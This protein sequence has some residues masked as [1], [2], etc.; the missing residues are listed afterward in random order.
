MK[1][2]L[3]WFLVGM[4]MAVALAWA[5]PEPGSSGGW[6]H[7]H[8][9]TKLGV[10]LIFFLHG[11]LLSFADLREGTMRW[12]V[13]LLVQSSTFLIFPLLGLGLLA[14]PGLLPSAG[15]R[16]GVFLLCALPSTVSSSVALTAAARGNVP[17]AVFNATLS[18][19]LGFVLTPLWIGLLITASGQ[20]LPLGQVILDLFYWLVL[21]L[22]IGQLIRPWLGGWAQHHK[23]SINRVDRGVILFLVYTS[24]CDSM[25]R[26]IWTENGWKLIMLL[27]VI[28]I[29]L[30]FVI[31]QIVR[32]LIRLLRFSKEDEIATIFCGSQKTLAAGIPIAQLIFGGDPRMGMILLPIIIY[33]PLQLIIS[34]VLANRWSRR[35]SG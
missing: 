9:L 28:S 10:A 1:L 5:W 26:G 23:K 30:F 24:F 32:G 29:G 17:V 13:H 19:L 8:M 18:N 27:I 21:P 22:V 16:L 20:G 4:G 14:I 31:M 2:K 35:S 33:H 12:P 6:M 25:Q 15:L 11:L 34:S 3:D 7:A